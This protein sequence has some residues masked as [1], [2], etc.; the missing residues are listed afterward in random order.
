MHNYDERRML[1]SCLR[2]WYDTLPS[3]Q[4][5]RQAKSGIM[6]VLRASE[7]SFYQLLRGRVYLNPD[8]RGRIIQI[9]GDI[10]SDTLNNETNL[11]R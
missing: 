6:R 10:F 2:T 8:K 4:K 3:A 5:R 9:T 1:A 7:E 11:Q